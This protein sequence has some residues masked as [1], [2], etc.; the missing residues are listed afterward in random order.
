MKTA[1]LDDIPPTDVGG[2][3]LWKPIRSTL[4]IRAFGVNAH[5]A[6]EPGA[7]I[8]HEHD[9]TEAGAGAQRHEE[10]YVVLRGRATFIVDGED[11]DAPAGTLVFVDD[12]SA[13]RAAAALEEGTIVLAIGGPVGEAYEVPPWEAWFLEKRNR[14]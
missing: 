1:H 3:N 8:I 11:V 10:L 2:G 12:P 13:R 7:A 5:V 6:R 14:D 4:G 9:E